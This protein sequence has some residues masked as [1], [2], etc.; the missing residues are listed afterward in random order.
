DRIGGH[1]PVA[2]VGAL[3]EEPHAALEASCR[4]IS[5]PRVEVRRVADEG[6]RDTIAKVRRGE[7]VQEIRL[8]LARPD[9]PDA[10]Q[11]ETSITTP[12]IE[13]GHVLQGKPRRR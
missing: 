1:D 3:A 10:C 5:A 2:D 11:D 8:T 9:G 6:A 7:R 12:A 13:E 4:G